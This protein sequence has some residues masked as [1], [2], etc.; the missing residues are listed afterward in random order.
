MPISNKVVSS[1]QRRASWLSSPAP[2]RLTADTSTINRIGQYQSPENTRSD[3]CNAGC[4]R[5][6]ANG[7]LRIKWATGRRRR[8]TSTPK[9]TAANR[10]VNTAMLLVILPPN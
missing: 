2:I 1:A 3:C 9:M 5:R 8:T 4:L 10:P 6:W 7:R